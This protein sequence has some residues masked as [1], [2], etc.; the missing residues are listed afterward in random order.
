MKKL[1]LLFFVL[2]F[3]GLFAPLG[4]AEKP[5]VIRGK[6]TD[7]TTGQPII[8]A[9]V[10][11]E[12]TTRGTATDVSGEFLL[13]GLEPG[14]YKLNISFISYKTF[15]SE[16]IDLKPDQSYIL[17]VTLVEEVSQLENIVVVAT[18]KVSSDA[19]LLSQMRDMS[20]VASGVSGQA[21]ARTQD[22]DASEVVKRI[23]GISILDDK[24]VVVR[25]LAQRYNNVWINGNT[26]PSLESDS[27]VFSFDMLPSSQIENM[28]IYKSP[29]PEIPADFAGGFIRITTK[30]LPLRNSVQVN[31]TTGFNTS[32]QFTDTRLNPGSSTDWLG[33]DLSK[34]PLSSSMPSHMD[35]AG[36]N[37]DEVTRLTRSFNSDWRVKS[38]I[39]M[40][41]QR[42]SLTV[43]RRFDTEGGTEIGMTTFINYSNTYKTIQDIVNARF[44]VYSSEADKPVY[45]DDYIDNQ[46]SNDVRVGAMHNWSF[47]FSD[48]NKI[49]FRNLFNMLGKNRLTE[50]TGE[51]N[52]SSPFYR[53]ETEMLYQS[54][55]TY[56]GQLAGNH[57]LDEHKLHSLSWNVGYSYAYK[58]EPD[59][60]IIVNQAGMS[61]GADVSQL[62]VGNEEISRYFQSLSDHLFSGSV[63]YKGSVNLGSIRSTVKGGLMGEY[64]TRSYTPREFV[65][66]YDN[67]T[68]IFGLPDT[69]GVGIS[70]GA[71]R[72]YDVML[73]LDKFPKEAV[74]GTE[75]LFA[76]MGKET[77][78][79]I[80]KAAARCRAAGHSAEIYP[81][82]AKLRKQFEYA[83]KKGIKYV[84]LAGDDEISNNELSIKDIISG[85]QK[86][87]KIFELF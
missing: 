69:S 51:R 38:Y 37:P 25:G 66:R 78:P 22:R 60:R 43:N 75:Y 70:F 29:A 10:I 74:Q 40:P 6:V 8:G 68:G 82:S 32:T 35:V 50:R 34:R 52:I 20:L 56:L 79:Y 48:H 61:E 9:A 17:N 62:K 26:A 81:D 85:E 57:F 13:T 76:N 63:D 41:D 65:Y 72:I 11:L 27:R 1:F 55:L 58:T 73:G 86:K 80:L 28:I 36:S 18:R 33:F 45:L 54:R 77:L 23:P 7:A 71:D 15:T 59:R 42:L 49:E 16:T 83:D 31:Y 44:G 24:F 64:R 53:E 39:P 3:S 5:G 19:G 47:V 14:P 67:L 21:I 84:I 12:G 87:V 30:S 4:A 2:C 46:Y